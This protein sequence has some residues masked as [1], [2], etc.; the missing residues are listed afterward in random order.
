MTR[1]SAIF[2]LLREYVGKCV[3][4]TLSEGIGKGWVGGVE[5]D[6]ALVSIRDDMPETLE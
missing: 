4:G 6:S 3:G 1:V 2:S 5:V